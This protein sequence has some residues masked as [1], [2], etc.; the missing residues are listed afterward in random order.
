MKQCVSR[1][2]LVTLSFHCL[3][4]ISSRLLRREYS[5]FPEGFI[6]RFY[7]SF[8]AKHL[9]NKELRSISHAF[10]FRN[11]K[12]G[13]KRAKN[14]PEGG[15]GEKQRTGQQ[16]TGEGTVGNKIRGGTVGNKNRGGTVGNKTIGEGIE[17][18]KQQG[19]KEQ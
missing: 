19:G 7:R 1:K 11:I 13:D 12:T 5:V 15:T 2:G 10:L 18:N 8:R 14:R 4:T 6:E 3:S 17:E 9:C 16:P